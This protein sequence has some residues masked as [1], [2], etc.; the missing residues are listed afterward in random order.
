MYTFYENKTVLLCSTYVYIFIGNTYANQSRLSKSQFQILS[1]E[2]N[3]Y[4]YL[5]ICGV[6]AIVLCETRGKEPGNRYKAVIT[7]ALDA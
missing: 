1:V 3:N 6:C 7:F 2:I 5:P 4:Q